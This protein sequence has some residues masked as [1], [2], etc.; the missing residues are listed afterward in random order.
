MVLKISRHL[1][2]KVTLSVIFGGSTSLE[3]CD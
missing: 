1:P 3:G 2:V